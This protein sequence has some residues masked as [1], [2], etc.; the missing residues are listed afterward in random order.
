[1]GLAIART[2]GACR[3][4]IRTES[5]NPAMQMNGPLARRG[6]VVAWEI[7]IAI[8]STRVLG[9]YQYTNAIYSSIELALPE[10]P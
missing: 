10:N 7:I 1:M 8:C 9:E 5:L 2:V 3:L 6:Q 4:A